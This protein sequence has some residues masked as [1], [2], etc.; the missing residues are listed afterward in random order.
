MGY[1]FLSGLTSIAEDYRRLEPVAEAADAERYSKLTETK[2][3]LP[4]II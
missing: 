4:K 1:F 2:L 3:W